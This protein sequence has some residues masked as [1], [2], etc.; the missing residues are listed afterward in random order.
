MRCISIALYIYYN[1]LGLLYTVDMYYKNQRA[2]RIQPLS[3]EVDIRVGFVQQ[4]ACYLP[5]R[6]LYWLQCLSSSS[7]SSSSAARCYDVYI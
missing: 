7:S 5:A 6:H 2:C 3:I 4:S 1:Q